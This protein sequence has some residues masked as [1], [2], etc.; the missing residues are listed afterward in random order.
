MSNDKIGFIGTGNM[1]SALLRAAARAV[2]P[3]RILISN[4]TL[5]KSQ[6]LAAEVGAVVSDNAEIAAECKMIFLGVKPQMMAEMLKAIA[7]VLE[8]REDGFILVSMAAGVTI[9]R[10]RTMA[11]SPYPVIRIMP[12]LA[13]SVGESMTQYSVS[14]NVPDDGMALFLDVIRFAGVCDELPEY[15]IDVGC[16]VSGCGPAFA[17]VFIEALADGGV[18]CGLP[19]DRAMK[20]AAQTLCG[21][22]KLVLGS[23]KHPGE[24]KDMVCNP[25]GSTI[26]G[27]HA[28]ESRGFR[29][30]AMDAI[31]EAYQKTVKLGETPSKFH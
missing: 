17:F 21:A 14:D 12:N 23:G 11:G 10:I 5:G 16:A 19:R 30:A 3:S 2:D 18:E 25:G 4:R 31:T 1:G 15:L 28:L 29:A 24:L 13:A 7:P 6:A 22:A 20:Y 9:D 26:V 8:K 27:I